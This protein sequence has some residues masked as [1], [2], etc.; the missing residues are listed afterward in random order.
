M[1]WLAPVDRSSGGRSAVSSSS[2]T[3]DWSASSDRRVQVGR[4][5]PRRGDHRDRDAG[6]LGQ[7]R[8]R[9]S[10]RCARRCARAA[11]AG[12]RRRR[13]AGPAP[14]AST[15]TP[16]RA[17]PRASRTAAARRP[18]PWPAR[19]TGS[20]LPLRAGASSCRYAAASRLYRARTPIHATGARAHALDLALVD[21]HRP[22]LPGASGPPR[23]PPASTSELPSG[24]SFLSSRPEPQAAGEGELGQRGGQCQ[25]G[26]QAHRGV[27]RGR[28]HDRQARRLRRRQRRPNPPERGHLQ[29]QDVGCLAQAVD[30]TGVRSPPYPLVDGDRHVG[31]HAAAARTRRR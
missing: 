8:A 3:P 21:R 20:C 2:G 22:H 17:R 1:V 19:S 28:D 31:R 7:A 5:R 9:G 18:A 11:A 16:G 24:A 14:A 4:S 27:Q 23:S 6:R 12:P 10:R 13:R 29:H 15:A 26:S 30:V 25:A